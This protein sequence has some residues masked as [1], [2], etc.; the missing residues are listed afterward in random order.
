MFNMSHDDY[1]SM[2]KIELIT[3]YKG[4]Y[5]ELVLVFLYIWITSTFLHSFLITY[6]R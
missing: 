3:G 5:R 1:Y 4:D 6:L 2:L